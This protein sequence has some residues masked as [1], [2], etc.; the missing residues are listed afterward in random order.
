[1]GSTNR[2]TTTTTAAPSTAASGPAPTAAPARPRPDSTA[3]AEAYRTYLPALTAQVTARLADGDLDVVADLVHDAFTAALADPALIGADVL[4]S[5]RRLCDQAC[6]RH[7]WSQRRYLA[8]AHSI[9]AD[10]HTDRHPAP[11]SGRPDPVAA[12]DA[13]TDDQRQVAH[14][15][16]LDGLTRKATAQLLGRSVRSVIYLERHACRRLRAHLTSTTTTP[17]STSTPGTL[18]GRA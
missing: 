7:L 8:A 5:L 17:G 12:L 6:T 11:A 15:R 3:F 1:M 16:F 14:L 4:A 2:H 13:L 18:T 9:Y 10:Q